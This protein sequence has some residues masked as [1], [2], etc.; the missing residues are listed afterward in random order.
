[1]TKAFKDDH[2]AESQLEKVVEKLV[3]QKRVI[4]VEVDGREVILV[5][6][7]ERHEIVDLGRG[8]CSCKSFF[9]KGEPCK[10]L[11][12]AKL[13]IERG[14]ARRERIAAE[15]LP[16]FVYALLLEGGY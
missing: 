9:Y 1:L 14:L 16:L 7:D 5:V 2:G 11:A 12:A 10:H 6:G 15:E 13:A 3:L 8:F 4:V